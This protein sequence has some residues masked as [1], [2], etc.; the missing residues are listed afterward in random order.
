MV[1]LWDRHPPPDTRWRRYAACAGSDLN[2]FFPVGR[3]DTAERQATIARSVCMACPVRR[4][5]RQ[6]AIATQTTRRHLR[7]ADSPGTQDAPGGLVRG[8]HR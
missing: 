4:L 8:K 3:G 6:Y 1:E 7:R 2:L 5:C